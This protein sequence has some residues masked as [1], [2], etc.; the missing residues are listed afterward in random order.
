[1]KKRQRIIENSKRRVELGSFELTKTYIA[2]LIVKGCQYCGETEL[3]KTG[4]DRIDNS[5]GYIE[6]NVNPCC[7]TCNLIR[8]DMPYE[9]WLLFAVNLKEIREKELLKGW[10]LMPFKKRKPTS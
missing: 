3:S 9:A 6:S 2:S 10:E 7:I 5:I 8:K 4:L 1:M